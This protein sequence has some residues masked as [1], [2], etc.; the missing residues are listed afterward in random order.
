MPYTTHT[1]TQD[2]IY[3][4]V[5]G[6][7]KDKDMAHFNKYF[8]STFGDLHMDFDS[9]RQLLALQGKGAKTVLQRLAPQLQVDKIK[10]MT[11]VPSVTV[12][13]T[14]CQLLVLVLLT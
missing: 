9:D 2:H 4:V 14:G 11:G 12:A 1:R 13:G 8:G 7:C 10:F 6:A 5:N 3:M